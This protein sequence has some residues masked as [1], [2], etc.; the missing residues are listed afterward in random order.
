MLSQQAVVTKI[1]EQGVWLSAVRQ[2]ACGSCQQQRACQQ[3]SDW[4]KSSAQSSLILVSASQW[5]LHKGDVV[6][7]I[8]P[9][10][11]LWQGLIYLYVLPLLALTIGALFGQYYAQ[12]VGAVLFSMSAFV[13]TLISIHYTQQRQHHNCLPIISK[14]LT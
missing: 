12:E 10:Q 2:S 14:K 11:Q 7:I 1:D 13:V 4:L 6:E 3:S 5:V 8:I 9:E